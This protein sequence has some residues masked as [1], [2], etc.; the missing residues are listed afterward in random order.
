M[1]TI[2]AVLTPDEIIKPS[3]P[4]YAKESQ[5][6]SAHKFLH[7]QIVA[8]PKTI[9]TLSKLLQALNDSDV[10]FNVRS[11]GCGNASS[12]NV[13]ISMTAFDG[14]EF[15]PEEGKGKEYVV[16]GAGQLWRD[17]DRKVEEFARG[18]SGMWTLLVFSCD[19][20]SEV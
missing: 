14:F 3:H 1:D 10:E 7:P 16:V 20:R 13:L 15:H 9:E 17:V 2:L 6:W 5:V 8:R 12:K 18:Y 11:G 19:A 4:A